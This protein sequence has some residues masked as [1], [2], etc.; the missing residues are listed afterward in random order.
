MQRSRE[1]DLELATQNL[2]RYKLVLLGT[3]KVG[4]TSLVNRLVNDRFNENYMSTL[5]YNVFEKQIV[6]E[7]TTISLLIF[8]IGGQEKFRELRKKYVD[9][10]HAAFLVFDITN[11]V[12]FN[13]LSAWK[14]DL[15]EF[16]GPIPF[17]T[18]GNK[19]DLDDL[20]DIP[21]EEAKKFTIEELG[22]LSYLETSAKTGV[23]V[24]AAFQQLGL[25]TYELTTK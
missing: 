14:K 8:D 16:V 2:V 4:K 21:Q 22:A 17:I 24:E 18:I 12:S 6:L 7:D 5:G 20:R 19:V 9:R 15:D 3:E 23:G 13:A 10:A 25:K 1:V 11:Q